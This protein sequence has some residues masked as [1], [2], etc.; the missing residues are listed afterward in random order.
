MNTGQITRAGVHFL[1]EPIRLSSGTHLTAEKGCRLVGGVALSDFVHQPGGVYVCD[2][3]AAGIEPARFVSRGFGRKISPSHCELFIDGKPMK[4]ARYPK[5]D[6]LKISNVGDQSKNEWNTTVGKLEGGFYYSDERP[7]MWKDGD[8]WVF[9]YWAYDWSPTRERIEV[10]DKESGFIRCAEPYGLYSYIVGQRF[11]FFNIIDEVTCPG[12]YAFDF[13]NKL[14]YFMPPEDFDPD[15]SEVFIS[16][17]DRPAFIIEDVQDVSIG[18]FTIECFRGNGIEVKGAENVLISDCTLHGIGNRAVVVDNSK[19]VVVSGC[20]VYNTGDGGIEI[21][22]GDRKTL[23]PSGCGVENCHIHHVAAWDRCYEPPIKLT[24]VGLFARGNLIHD[25]PHTAILYGG[26]E[27]HIENNEI[28]RVVLETG[29][30]G[31]IY[32]GRD[33]TM[34]GNVIEGNFIHHV[35]SGIGMGTMGVYNDDCLSG[36]VMRNNVM[37]K[38]QRA[39]FLGGGLDFICDGNILIECTPGIEIDGRGQS[40]HAV[41][42]NMVTKYMRSRFYNV[43]DT[44]VS[45]AEPPYITKYPELKKI[46]DYYKASDEPHFPPSALITGNIFVVNP[47]NNEEQRVKLTWSVEGGTFDMENNRDATLDEIL[48]ILTEREQAVITGNVD[49]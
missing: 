33:F 18:G 10:W 47:D 21:W 7:K 32:A 5:N 20:H 16:T 2:L 12:E 27:I 6:F 30:A 15:S 45:A 17:C 41:W 22:S 13:E 48:P 19:N 39:L 35:G 44:G 23:T 43:D 24:G 38:V 9:G 34:R 46:D 37:Y 4:M 29:D 42:R 26:N 14:L 31:A 1:T 11:C 25:C 40:D 8:I 3:A 28:Y 36:T 49:I